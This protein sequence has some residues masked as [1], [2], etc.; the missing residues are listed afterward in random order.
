VKTFGHILRDILL[1]ALAGLCLWLFPKTTLAIE[2]LCGLGTLGMF[3]VERA[4]A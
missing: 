3:L 1:L 4:M 2:G